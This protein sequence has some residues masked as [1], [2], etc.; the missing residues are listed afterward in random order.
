MINFN[1]NEIQKINSF[2]EL[3]KKYKERE[4]EIIFSSIKHKN[5]CPIT[6][7]SFIN[8]LKTMKNSCCQDSEDK[9][10]IKKE[11]TTSLDI[12]LHRTKNIDNNDNLKNIRIKLLEVK[13]FLYI[14]NIII[15]IK[16]QMNF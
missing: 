15:L 7:N 10:W 5:R 4:L 1:E 16:F 8:M 13:I 6:R 2:H 9:E 11:Q 12:R 3:K 14:V